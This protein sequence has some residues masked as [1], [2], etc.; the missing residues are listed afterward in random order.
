MLFKFIS[1]KCIR[2]QSISPVV[3]AVGCVQCVASAEGIPGAVSVVQP[4]R[5]SSSGREGQSQRGLTETLSLCRG[6]ELSRS[7]FLA[8]LAMVQ[9]GLISSLPPVSWAFWEPFTPWAACHVRA[10]LICTAACDG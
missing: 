4:Q 3:E 2:G 5:C 10:L 8:V 9:Q 6:Q 1:T 7:M